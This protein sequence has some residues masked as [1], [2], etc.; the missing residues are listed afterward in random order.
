MG[1]SFG[2]RVAILSGDYAYALVG[3]RRCEGGLDAW[4]EDSAGYGS[5]G[6]V[7]LERVVVGAHLTDLL[8]SMR[9]SAVYTIYFS[10]LLERTLACSLFYRS[11]CLLAKHAIRESVGVRRGRPCLETD[12]IE[13]HIIPLRV[14]TL[15]H[16]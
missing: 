14:V 12:R 7:A 10:D 6:N 16:A 13:N 5:G 9:R 15:P 3:R 8:N 2:R 1:R 4:R 11:S